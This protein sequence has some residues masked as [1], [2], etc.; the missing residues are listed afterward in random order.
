MKARQTLLLIG[1]LVSLA[2]LPAPVEA[3]DWA[4][5][6]VFAAVGGGMYRVYRN[7]GTFKETISD[8]LGGFTTG[9][10]LSRGTSFLYT[11]NFSNTKVVKRSFGHPHDIVQTI[12]TGANS[13]ES[14]VFDKDGNFYVGH[15]GPSFAG[16]FDRRIY[17]YD[18]SGTLQATFTA[19]VEDRGT[20]WIDLAADQKTMF[21]TSEGRKIFRFDV[22]GEGAQL[23]TFA[24]L[25]ASATPG[26]FFALRLLPPGDGSGGLL[27]ADSVDIK[28]LG[29]DGTVVKT[30]D[31]AGEDGWFA[32][33]LDPNGKSFWAGGDAT[34]KFYR[35]QIDGAVDFELG[36]VPPELGPIDTG[37]E[38]NLFGLCVAGEPRVAGDNDADGVIN[39]AD[40]CPN[41]LNP[42]PP[43]NPSEQAVCDTCR[44]DFLTPTELS[45]LGCPVGSA[46]ET[47]SP[48]EGTF[49]QGAPVVITANFTP[50]ST[51]TVPRPDCYNTTFTFL[52]PTTGDP[53]HGRHR[54]R[55]AYGIYPGSPDIVTIQGGKPFP[56]Q[57]DV[58]L[59]YDFTP[60]TTSQY[61]ATYA[62]N[63]QDPG[64]DPTTGTCTV[65]PCVFLS[66]VVVT[67]PTGSV[68]IDAGSSVTKLLVDIKPGGFPNSWGCRSDQA[69][70]VA[71]LSTNAFD[72]TTINADTVKFGKIGSPGTGEVHLKA[73][74]A[75]RHVIDVNGDG[76]L[77]MVFHFSF[78]LT[79]FLCTD[80]PLG[81]QSITLNG[82]LTGKTLASS[83]T[84][85][86]GVDTIRL[87]PGK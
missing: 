69:I 25:T 43:E 31:A 17:K 61:F 60:G 28:R 85:V 8:G 39:A 47:P 32:L 51:I 6:D 22:S 63:Q 41:V 5:G 80:I 19:A 64:I 50:D 45:F 83:P 58:S 23:T 84:A 49:S 29:A 46:S 79:G 1:L 59:N 42:G 56:V 48:I 52:D 77:D 54:H 74:H 67:S 26:T 15:A 65:P 53:M 9:C 71:V 86:T 44:L 37:A 34:R 20:D 33:A 66:L 12:A 75:V 10:A 81:Q 38:S 40:T 30:Y 21:Y 73:G 57:C 13:S 3:A 68:T 55:T 87:V 62:N 78:P 4:I 76:K 16:E 27:V 14:I 35:F 24:D 7:D 11:T 18:P 82:I 36:Y 72:A 70:P 2:G